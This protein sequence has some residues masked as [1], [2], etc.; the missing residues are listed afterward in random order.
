MPARSKTE[1]GQVDGS[2]APEAA[3]A[4][5]EWYRRTARDLPWRRTR[6]PYRIL[7]SEIMLQQTRVE[8]VEPRFE[9]FL[10]RFPDLAALAAASEHEVLAEW[11][12]LGYYRRARNLHRLAGIVVAEYH[13][14]LPTDVAPL[15]ALPGIGDYTAAA[16][17]SIARDLPHLAIDGNVERVLCR[18]LDI[19]DDP[20][21]AATKRRLREA[22]AAALRQHP[23]G[24]VN[25]ALMDLGAR[26]CIPRT[27]RCPECP[28]SDWCGA[29]ARGREATIPAT[30]RA[31]IVD[32][33]EAAAVIARDGRLLLFRG[34]R[35]GTLRGMWEFPTLDSRLRPP[36]VAERT[37]GPESTLADE[38]AGYLRDNEIAVEDFTA[39]GRVRH[40]IT[41]R[42]ITC[43]VF[44]V[45]LADGSD[46][47]TGAEHGWFD[48]S[49][50][51]QL[52]LAAATRK[53]LDLLT[54]RSDLPGL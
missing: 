49:E 37:D 15:R 18:V 8:T 45:E 46:P 30:R 5:V 7:V 19:D 48:A 10:Q 6:D 34:Q 31:D 4:L 28:V 39:I 3:T 33:Q 51:E 24:T 50:I 41:T 17:S 9:R 20:R 44:R 40:S 32:V 27:P 2:L 23:A 12:G 11:S 16:V 1:P 43:F 42:R 38:L 36:V 52:P 21:R 22:T 54:A 25:Q 47:A 14:Q 13:G 29:R 35:A 53:I 26:V